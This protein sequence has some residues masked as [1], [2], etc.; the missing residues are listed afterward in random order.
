MCDV[1]VSIQNKN[2]P[3]CSKFSGARRKNCIISL[4]LQFEVMNNEM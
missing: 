1:Y 4:L 3:R 2:I